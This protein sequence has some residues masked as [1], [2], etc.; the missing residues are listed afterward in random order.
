M[1]LSNPKLISSNH[2]WDLGPP[3]GKKTEP[4]LRRAADVKQW[5]CFPPIGENRVTQE[6]RASHEKKRPYIK[7]QLKI[8]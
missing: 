8:T 5:N 4:R 6:M 3:R 2:H 1:R 7:S